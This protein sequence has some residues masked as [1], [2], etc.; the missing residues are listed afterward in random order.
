MTAIYPRDVGRS[1]P[2][3]DLF[4][5][6]QADGSEIVRTLAARRVLAK[7]DRGGV[8]TRLDVFLDMEAACCFS[9]IPSSPAGDINLVLAGSYDV[10]TGEAGGWFMHPLEA[11]LSSFWMPQP[12][13]LRR[14]DAH[15]H[16][17]EERAAPVTGLACSPTQIDL[18]IRVPDGWVLDCTLWRFAPASQAWLRELQDLLAQETQPQLLWGSHTLYRRPADLYLHLV[19]GHVYENRAT[20]PKHWK[21]FSENDAHALYTVLSGLQ[22]ATGK[23]FYRL[24]K[25]Q[26]VLSV[27]DRQGEDGGWR[28]GEWTDRMEAHFR[29]H[30]SAMHLLMD[31]LAERRDPAIAK[32]LRRAADFL[33]RQVDRLDA[34]AWLL[35]DELELSV[36]AMGEGPFRWLPSRAL[37]KSPANMLV[38][39]SH[40]DGTIA[41]HRY[42]ELTGDTRHES[43]VTDAR[44][45]TRAVMSLRPAEWLYAALFRAIHLTFMPTAQ[46]ARL[47]L[48]RRALKR[49]AW[50]YLIP[51]LPRIKARFPRIV[52]PGGYIERELTL[53]ALA[54]D[55]LPINLMDLL[56]YARRFPEDSNDDVVRAA[57]RLIAECRMFERWPEIGKAYA[58]GFW[59]EAL[60]RACLADPHPEYR[61]WLAQAVL[62]LE[63]RGLGLP[64]SLLGANP[65]AV[66]IGGQMAM[67]LPD[68]A[69]LRVVN[70]CTEGRVE[71]LFVNCAQVAVRVRITRNF[72]HGL[73][74]A[75][76]AG[77]ERRD[78]VPDAIP[79]REW[80]WGRRI[81]QT[82]VPA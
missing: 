23:A 58:I 31:A 76:G 67:P 62:E 12:P 19:H 46:A 14:L 7:S 65:E 60:Y 3:G 51:L 72:P 42:G 71:V 11:G 5:S 41:L 70:L 50:K 44:R 75:V 10:T 61:S 18:K 1:Y 78:T 8:Q 22:S 4:T 52:M 77:G 79:A 64:P 63:D 81:P 56:R 35:H 15:G 69:R 55:Y 80:L 29:L 82:A 59:A 68:D 26:L 66:A 49:L 16:V 48:H 27:I 6:T 36:E 53:R 57:F 38:L 40:L 30:C 32:A 73:A 34:G 47:P 28:H 74:W 39:N 37:G 45:A 13:T 24:L 33:S 25:Q 20:W 17:L 54:H 2:V 43:L 9:R 21:I